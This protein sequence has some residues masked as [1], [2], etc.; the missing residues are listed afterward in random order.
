MFAFFFK[1]L[2]PP[3]Y[4]KK[5]CKKY[6]IH[7]ALHIYLLQQ[8]QFITSTI[9]YVMV[10]TYILNNTKKAIKKEVKAFILP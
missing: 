10:Q 1:Y 5:I 4:Y 9:L 2:L 8:I 7:P 6:C 3:F